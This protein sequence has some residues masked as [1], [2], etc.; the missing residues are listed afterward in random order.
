MTSNALVPVSDLEKM[1]QAVAASKLFG[2]TNAEQALALMLVAQAEGLHPATAARDYHIIQGRP[3]LKADAMLARYL[4]SGGSVQWHDHTDQKVSAT[5]THPQGGSLTIDWD[6]ARAKAAGLGSKD[7]WLKYPRQMLRARVISEGIRATNPGIS[8]GMYTPEE[9]QDM[10]SAKGARKEKN[11]G[12]A[13]VIPE[14][15]S[16]QEAQS[17]P[18]SSSTQPA[19]AV[20]TEELKALAAKTT[21]TV[22]AILA[23]AGCKSVEEMSDEDYADACAMLRAWKPKVKA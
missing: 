18:T 20:R 2:V 5:F 15:Q 12:P 23:K 16:R 6:F 7:M 19:G 10:E 4:A 8:I 1:A 21:I 3:T 22:A 13:I 17:G 9:A 11:M 14:D